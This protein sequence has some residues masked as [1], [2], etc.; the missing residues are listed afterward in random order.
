MTNTYK[1]GDILVSGKYKRKVLGVC[2]EVYLL[3]DTD[4]HERY[5]MIGT[6][7]DLADCNY[8]LE[9]P[10]WKPEYGEIYW[11]LDSCTAST[12]TNC[13]GNFFSDHFNFKTGNCFKTQEE[14][15]KY[16]QWLLDHPYLPE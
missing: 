7:K 11:Y 2:G 10:R 5:Y 3:S 8:T 6:Q 4:D 12:E 9:Q 14:A 1:E 16:K 13:W 15:G